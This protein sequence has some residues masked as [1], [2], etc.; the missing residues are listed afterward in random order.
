M[1]DLQH[2]GRTVLVV[3]DEQSNRLLL[4]TLLG[5]DG[6]HVIEVE[7]GEQ[8]LDAINTLQIDIILLDIQMPVMDGYTTA[9]IIKQRVKRF[10]PIIFLT[11]KTDEAS[12]VKCI[13]A[14]GDDFL[15]KPFNYLLLTAKLNSLLRIVS[16]Y[17]DIE[18]K[19]RSIQQHNLQMMQE[20]N[21]TK[22]VFEKVSKNDMRGPH[23]GLKYAMSPM[24]MFN[25]DVI[26]AEKNQTS[27]LDLMIAD[28]TG[29]GLSAAIGAIPIADVFHTMTRKCFLFTDVLA[30][31]NNKLIDLL[32]TQ[33]FMAAVMLS[34]DRSNNIL[35]V[36]NAGLPDVYLYRNNEIIRSFKSQN[37]PLGI[38]KMS[39]SQFEVEMQPL[40]YG[41]R[42]YVFTDGVMEAANPQGEMFGRNRVLDAFSEDIPGDDLF[43]S[44][45]ARCAEFSDGAEQTDDITLLELCHQPQVSYPHSAEFSNE[46]REPSNWS[47][48][49]DLDIK[50]LRQFDALPY[51]MQAVNNLQPLQSGRTRLH[52]ILTEMF[53]NALD[54]GLLKLDSSMKDSPQGYMAF[55][56]E[57]QRRLEQADEGSINISL[58]HTLQ[59]DGRGG[60]LTLT[61]V[62]SGDGYD[63]RALDLGNNNAYSGRGLKLVSSLCT[64]MKILGKGNVITALYDWQADLS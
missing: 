49:F 43:D 60:R 57:K 6:Y 32:P 13:E 2:H 45:L 53:A 54:H 40:E 16:L 52:T 64:E 62:D 33:M 63:Y 38:S 25:G 46:V 42:L 59:E 31:A 58:E 26:M 48:Q 36:V 20:M 14:G 50:S 1:N 3:D 27:G 35:S 56:Q 29:H 15:I 39:S 4:R 23:T 21:V 10:I 61:V 30:E 34:V 44:I 24:S 22:K 55:Y 37:I 7:N 47:L 17:Q 5:R 28:F 8:A 12:L 18:E 41:D 19:N 11:A 9:S 51:I